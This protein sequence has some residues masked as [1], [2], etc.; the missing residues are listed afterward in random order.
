MPHSAEWHIAPVISALVEVREPCC[1][2]PCFAAR[3]SQCCLVSVQCV[4]LVSV[5]LMQSLQVTN[6]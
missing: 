5:G 2:L 3:I 1:F 4:L 6:Q